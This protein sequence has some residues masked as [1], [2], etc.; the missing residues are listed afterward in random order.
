MV[1]IRVK[2]GMGNQLFQYA[3]YKKFETLGKEVYIDLGYY[4]GKRLNGHYALDTLGLFPKV[5]DKAMVESLAGKENLWGKVIRR[6]GLKQTYIRD[7]TLLY[8]PDILDMDNVYLNGYWQSEKYFEDIRDILLSEI[9]FPTDKAGRNEELYQK[10][11]NTES[12]CVTIRRGDYLTNSKHKKDYYVCDE[13]YFDEGMRKIKEDVGSPTFFAFSDDIEWVKD[14][15]RFPGE[16]F[17][18]R[19]DDPIYEKMRLMSACRHF[20]ISNS[21]FSW[22]VQY[23]SKNPDKIVYAPRQWYADGRQADIYQDNWKY[24]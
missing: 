10:I 22:W 13:N 19:G 14:N 11:R 7:Y 17:Y 16:V 20:L 3:L 12:V 23:L 15:I 2:S 5:A 24:V 4:E 8:R 9:T 1:I 6:A 21:S 18:E